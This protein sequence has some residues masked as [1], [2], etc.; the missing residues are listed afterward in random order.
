MDEWVGA[1]LR[2]GLCMPGQSQCMCVWALV[3]KC[4]GALNICLM[5]F[6]CVHAG[7]GVIGLHVC[8]SMAV[9]GQ[10]EPHLS[11]SHHNQASTCV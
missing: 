2:S 4:S 8:V 11:H 7:G 5:L 3:C 10:H 1:I 6:G 9:M